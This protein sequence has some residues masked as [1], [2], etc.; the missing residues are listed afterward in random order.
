[1]KVRSLRARSSFFEVLLIGEDDA[2][3]SVDGAADLTFVAAPLPVVCPYALTM[4][5]RASDAASR[6][7]VSTWL[8][9]DILEAPY[10][11]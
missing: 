3:S 9:F 2:D 4:N 10:G 8:A 6:A 1:M 5:T 11:R 7:A